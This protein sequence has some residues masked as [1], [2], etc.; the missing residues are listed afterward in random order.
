MGVDSGSDRSSEDGVLSVLV[1]QPSSRGPDSPWGSGLGGPSPWMP[2]DSDQGPAFIVYPV[3]SP[4]DG[5]RSAPFAGSRLS[6]SQFLRRPG[7]RLG[8]RSPRPQRE[9]EGPRALAP[10]RPHLLSLQPAAGRRQSPL[11]SCAVQTVGTGEQM[12]PPQQPLAPSP[13]W[14]LPRSGRR[15]KW[16]C[17]RQGPGEGIG[18]CCFQTV[19]QE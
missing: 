16:L 6:P 12:A 7:G 10:P 1:S 8:S 13:S 17:A 2:R 19:D 14:E 3:T 4:Y 15:L 5:N 11:G 18:L 9:A